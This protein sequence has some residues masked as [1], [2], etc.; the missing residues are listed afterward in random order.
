M[1]GEKIK[2][3]IMEQREAK[4]KFFKYSPQ[5]PIPYEKRSSFKGLNYYPVDL[6]LRFK[7]KLHQ[8]EKSEKVK[9]QDTMGG[10][11]EYIRWGKF[12]FKIEDKIQTLQVYKSSPNEQGLWVPFKD[13]TSGKETYGSGRY[14]DLNESS[15]KMNDDK[16]ILDFNAAYNPFCAYS[17]RYSCPYILPENCLPVKIEAGEKTPSGLH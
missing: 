9:V 3:E 7:L 16:W 12:I 17:T 13:E 4:D 15:F 6:S 8:Y 14:L 2:K 11:R 1:N 5:S 10:I